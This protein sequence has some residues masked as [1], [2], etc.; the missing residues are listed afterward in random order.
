M[1]MLRHTLL[2]ANRPRGEVSFEPANDTVG[3]TRLIIAWWIEAGAPGVAA[4]DTEF[5]QQAQ[6][7]CRIAWEMGMGVNDRHR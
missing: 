2:A 6:G 4:R 3:V 7:L 1:P 5:V